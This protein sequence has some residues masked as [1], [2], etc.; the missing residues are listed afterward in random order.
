MKK[1]VALSL[2]ITFFYHTVRTCSPVNIPNN[3]T[4]VWDIVVEDL[5]V[6]ITTL[7]KI[8][9]LESAL[10]TL[11]NSFS[12]TNII[13]NE[14][15]TI[16]SYVQDINQQTETLQTTV[17]N[18]NSLITGPINSKL[19]LIENSDLSIQ[20]T[21][22]VIDTRTTSIYSL[23]QTISS[24]IDTYGGIEQ[25]VLSKVMV[26]DSKVNNANLSC[27]DLPAAL[28]TNQSIQSIV[29][30]IDTRTSTIYNTDQTILS[31]VQDINNQAS[32]VQSV[33]SDLS[34]YVCNTV[35]SKVNLIENTDLSIQ[36]T[37]NVI[38]TRTTNIYNLD[39]SIS[40]Q[41]DTD[42]AINITNASITNNINSQLDS[43]G[44]ISSLTN[45][46]TQID[47]SIF[48]TAMVL[49]TR[50][51]N[52]QSLT[53]TILSLDKTTASNLT[54]IFSLDQGISSKVDLSINIDVTIQ[55]L[56]NDITTNIPNI[57]TCSSIGQL[58]SLDSSITSLVN[59]ID[60]RTSAIQ[61][62]TNLVYSL[63]QVISS[64]VD[65]ETNSDLSIQS[66][67]S[68]INSKTTPIQSNLN[69]IYSLDSFIYSAVA[70][71]STCCTNTGNQAATSLYGS[72]VVA[73]RLDNISVQFQYGIPT[74]SVTPYTQGGGT[75]TSANSM[76][77]LSTTA[78]AGSIA[79][80]QSNNTIVYR[81]GHEAYAYFTVAFT[82]SFAATSSQFIGPI[83]YQNGFAV[84][85][86]GATF[87]VTRRTNTV[88]TFTPQSQFNGDKLD[89]TGASG[90]TY[91]PA[92]LNVFRIA[93]GYLGSSIIKFQ[94]SNQTGNWITFH[95][96]PFPNSSSTPSILQPYLP[97]TAR[98]ENLTGAS[99]LKLQTASWNAGIV[100]QFNT[101]SFRYFQTNNTIT[102]D[103]GGAETFVL[104]I[105]NK[106]VFNNQPNKIPIRISAFGGG[107]LSNDGVNHN[108][109]TSR[110]RL[111]ATVT[112]TSFSDVSPGNSVVEV[113]TTG[114]YTAAT[115][116]ELLT[117]PLGSTTQ[118]AVIP[119]IPQGVYDIILLP[120]NTLTI[121]TQLSQGTNFLVMNGIAWEE[122]F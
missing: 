37:V 40:S 102:P 62:S 39:Q 13:A 54:N 100:G 9:T 98:V 74:Y 52:I 38:D 110:L 18:L 51:S 90:F 58:S 42:I 84:G 34:T 63:D 83:D 66:T 5:A 8:C 106:T 119:F 108:V 10:N 20:S 28:A 1:I 92:L 22:N 33:I 75:V 118:S 97:I 112:G 43:L 11:Q 69:T 91:N 114:T 35:T 67:V 79:Q 41:V 73:N 99:A 61:S 25:T 2:I 107:G 77:V 121:T 101:N 113:S 45:L 7:S 80:L 27:S 122:R 76:A 36:S 24:K 89:G 65:V 12:L 86:D 72:Q 96:I 117:R 95:T 116:T 60:T 17:N 50:T 47:Q 21:V 44:C 120:G 109:N 19:D 103:V 70:A 82:G 104:T 94:I 26:I 68:A 23:D 55:S 64:Q 105:R 32:T 53:N 57:A 85:F 4:R 71:L 56:L 16:E 3:G 88:N 31:Y 81:S 59:V 15:A 78:A 46:I 48:S 29:N 111:N 6:D 14:L 93:Y 30:V 115:G 49:D 87:G